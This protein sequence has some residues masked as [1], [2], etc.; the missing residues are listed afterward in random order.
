MK[1]RRHTVI[2][3]VIE[4][5][6]TPRRDCRG[7]FQRVYDTSLFEEFGLPGEW[8]QGNE[9]LSTE[10]NVVRGLHFQKPP[11]AETK[12]VRVV[13]G[14]VFDVF[15]DLRSD[16]PTNGQWGSVILDGSNAVVIPKGF[17]HGFCVIEA[18]AR[19]LYQVDSCYAPESEGGIRWNDADLAIPWPVENPV[20]SEKDSK[21]PFFRD[22]K[23][24]FQGMQD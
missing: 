23:D 15:V 13:E 16:S 11:H 17:A 19:M 5:E 10:S 24:I 21:L 3:D 20:L 12:F 4:V 7:Y 1:L 18:P 2:P 14:R 22:L 6:Y 9:S 8:V